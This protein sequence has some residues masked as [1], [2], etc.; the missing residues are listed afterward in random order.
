MKISLIGVYSSQNV[1]DS[2]ITQATIQLLKRTF[3]D[4]HISCHTVYSTQDIPTNRHLFQACY[5]EECEVLPSILPTRRLNHREGDIPY[6]RLVY[7]L[8]RAWLL[9]LISLVAGS[10]ASFLLRHKLDRKALQDM[11]SADLVVFCG[12]FYFADLWG[13]LGGLAHAFVELYPLILATIFRRPIVLLGVS[14]GPFRGKL[15]KWLV[16]RT[17]GKASRIFVREQYSQEFL[18]NA[19]VKPTKVAIIPDLAFSLRS[20]SDD[21]QVSH[22]LPS[23]GDGAKVGVVIRSPFP[24]A[25]RLPRYERYLRTIAALCDYIAESKDAHIF[26]IPQNT[27]VP[28]DDTVGLGEVWQLMKRK[29]QAEILPYNPSPQYWQAFYQ[30]LDMVVTSRFHGIVLSRPTPVVAIPTYGL[31]TR[32]RA[33]KPLAGYK[34]RGL[35]E[36][37]ELAEYCV[38]AELSDM[39]EVKIVVDKAWAQRS[40]IKAQQERMITNLLMGLE[41]V[42]QELRDLIK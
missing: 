28:D 41:H 36:M 31:G 6:P 8:L 39:E 30:E 13:G 7:Y 42:S 27:R 25:Q 10:K 21:M 16:K 11:S 1:G 20:G 35:M 5:E 18:L 4:S 2:A 19:G 37:L 24:E 38:D 12:R 40:N 14:I 3:L 33:N 22:Q 23:A 29:E 9:L 26:L 34:I 32:S 17:L 15:T